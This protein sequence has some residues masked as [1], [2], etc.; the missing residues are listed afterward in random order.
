[1]TN[2][3]INT[4]N[5]P[6]ISKW[7]FYFQHCSVCKKR[8]DRL[9]DLKRHLIEH[10]IKYRLSKNPINSKGTLELRCDV[11]SKD[12]FSRVDKYKAHLRYHAK[13][14]E[15]KCLTCD[16]SFSDSSNFSKH[17]KVHGSTYLQCDMCNR[18][19]NSKKTIAQHMEYHKRTAPRSCQYCDKIFHFE[20]TLK[21]HIKFNHNLERASKFRC[22]FCNKYFSSLKLKWD[23]DWDTH[24]I[25]KHIADCH[26]CDEK[27][28]KYSDLKRHCLDVHDLGIPKANKHFAQFNWDG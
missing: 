16:K 6:I 9:S 24:K 25:R 13:L 23:H 15:Y 28:R 2:L 27:F 8:F 19:F 1:M 12:V 17:K 3:W 22:K 7:Y 20:S 21:K 18:K 10:V 11:C 14:T 4:I 26:L 5:V